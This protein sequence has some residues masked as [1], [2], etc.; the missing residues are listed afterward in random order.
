MLI[1]FFFNQIWSLSLMWSICLPYKLLIK[2]NMMLVWY[3]KRIGILMQGGFCEF[4]TFNHLTL[5]FESFNGNT[6]L[7]L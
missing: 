7:K 6:I 1:F 5:G 3:Y 4:I 2:T